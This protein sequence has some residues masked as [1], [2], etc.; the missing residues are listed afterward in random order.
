[1]TVSRS[2]RWPYLVL[3]AE[4]LGFWRG[5]LF[6][7]RFAIPWDLRHYFLESLASPA[8]GHPPWESSPPPSESSP[9][10]RTPQAKRVVIV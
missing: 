3:L 8:S 2:V 7:G 10:S 5:V 4:I 6:T 1:M 9:T